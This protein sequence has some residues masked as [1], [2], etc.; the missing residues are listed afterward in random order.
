MTPC[1]LV[2]AHQHVFKSEKLSMF[3][4]KVGNYITEDY[5][6][7]IQV[8]KKPDLTIFLWMSFRCFITTD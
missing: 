4:R 2:G 5:S 3:L 7:N 6:V 1:S 8:R